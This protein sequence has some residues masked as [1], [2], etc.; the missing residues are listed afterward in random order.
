MDR[1]LALEF[2]RVTEAAAISAA[3]WIGRGDKH[4][5]DKAAVD[6]MR[7]RLNRIAFKGTIAIGEGQKDEAPELYNGET[8]GE[9]GQPQMD[10][11]VDPLECT[12]SVAN[13]RYNALSVIAS[14][15]ANCFL[16]APDTYMDKLAVGKEAAGVVDLEAPVHVNIRNAARALG[17]DVKEM[18]VIVL[19][20]P[21]HI[22]LIGKIRGSGAR[23]RLITDGDVAGGIAPCLADSGID[24]LLGVGASAEAV[25]AASA[26]RVMGGQIFCRFAPPNDA[27]RKLLAEFGLTNLKKIYE[28]SDLVSSQE[29][30]FT[31]T[32][33]IDGPLLEGVRFLPKSTV[34]H[35]LAMRGV[36]KTIRYLK[37]FHHEK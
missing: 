36:S 3:S 17:K 28:T 26:I 25:L 20:R 34:T 22:D 33:V 32:G 11:A 7:K 12:E 1:N 30:T 19:D 23:V 5:A 13:G 35:S 4:A 16:K 21:R 31:A 9:A 15:P 37:T 6:A 18:T 2:V 29:I 24:M 8:V 10:L 27:H 14:A